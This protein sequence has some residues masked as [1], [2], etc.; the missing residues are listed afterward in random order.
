MKKITKVIMIMVI[1]IIRTIM[2]WM[3]MK[4]VVI[5]TR[6]KIMSVIM[7]MI[8]MVGQW[9][10]W[11]WSTWSPWAEPLRLRCTPSPHHWSR[12]EPRGSQMRESS[13]ELATQNRRLP[14]QRV[15]GGVKHEKHPQS[16]FCTD[17]RHIAAVGIRLCKS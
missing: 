14:R 10:W 11:W 15:V 8:T 5:L 3:I 1:M 9:L 17:Q 6:M 7:M 2:M 4:M 12:D 16:W 13:T